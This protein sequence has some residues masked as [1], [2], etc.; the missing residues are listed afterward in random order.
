MNACYYIALEIEAGEEKEDENAAEYS[1]RWHLRVEW[2]E[3]RAGEV[4][5]EWWDR[6]SAR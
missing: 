3:R 5:G 2:W 1:V 6:V 4:G